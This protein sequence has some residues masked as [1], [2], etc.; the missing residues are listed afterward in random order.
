MIKKIFGKVKAAF[1]SC[2]VVRRFANDRLYFISYLS[3]TG[4]GSCEMS[5]DRK[6]ANYKDL[7]EIARIIEKD[8]P[9]QKDVI[10]MNWRTFV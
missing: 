9:E 5:L 6:P 10:V 4:H 8:S 1:V 2:S 7:I 3:K